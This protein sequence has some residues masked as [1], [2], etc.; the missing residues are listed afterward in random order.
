MVPRMS[1][2]TYTE[3]IA[4]LMLITGVLD[5]ALRFWKQKSDEHYKHA[6]RWGLG[7]IAALA[8]CF[9]STAALVAASWFRKLPVPS[10]DT[11]TVAAQTFEATVLIVMV[12]TF[13]IW[14]LAQML[15]IWAIHEHLRHDANERFGFLVT[16]IALKSGSWI[17]ATDTAEIVKALFHSALTA[18]VS[19][20][21]F[22][23]A[24]WT[25]LAK[26]PSG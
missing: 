18:P 4:E 12:V 21:Q 19:E 9:L 6:F 26:K 15:R 17:E 22:P 8:V 2:K 13:A 23:S 16:L 5:P 24:L 20:A 1:K 10:G 3:L 11:A 7:F 14:G 25:T